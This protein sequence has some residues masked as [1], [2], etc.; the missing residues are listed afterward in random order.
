MT[1]WLSRWRVLIGMFL[2]AGSAIGLVTVVFAY[3]FWYVNCNFG[4]GV[5][6]TVSTGPGGI[7]IQSHGFDFFS[8]PVDSSGAYNFCP[9]PSCLFGYGSEFRSDAQWVKVDSLD[10]SWSTINSASCID[11]PPASPT[12]RVPAASSATGASTPSLV[13]AP[14]ASPAPRRPVGPGAVSTPSKTRHGHDTLIR[15]GYTH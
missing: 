8:N 13:P 2:G 9:D 12:S 1:R 5:L 6:A 4:Q 3:D 7:F 15:I 10:N 14:S 11:P